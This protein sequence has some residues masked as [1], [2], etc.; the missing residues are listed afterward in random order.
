MAA[1]GL[2]PW[3]LRRPQAVMM[4]GPLLA[5]VAMQDGMETVRHDRDTHIDVNDD[6][7]DRRQRGDGMDQH[8]EIADGLELTRDRRREPEHEP[9]EEQRGAADHHQPEEL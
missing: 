1:G 6:A 8:R 5:D 4:P 7:A 9:R 3:R 2:D